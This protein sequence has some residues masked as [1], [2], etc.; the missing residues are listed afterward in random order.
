M[1]AMLKFKFVGQ[2]SWTFS[3]QGQFC[4]SS[5]VKLLF[6]ICFNAFFLFFF[7]FFGGGTVVFEFVLVFQNIY[8]HIDSYIKHN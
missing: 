8:F 4:I 1:A 5:L 7:L 3:L 6:R 2:F